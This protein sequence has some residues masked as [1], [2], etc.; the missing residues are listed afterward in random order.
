V[1]EVLLE[2]EAARFVEPLRALSFAPGVLPD[3]SRLR[4]TLSVEAQA[5]EVVAA[6]VGA[7]ARIHSVLRAARPLEEAYLDLVREED[8][9]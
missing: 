7:G 2:G 8:A 9:P 5:P 3:G 4:V 6:L 1:L